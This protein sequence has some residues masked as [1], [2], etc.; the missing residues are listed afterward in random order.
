MLP[1]FLNRFTSSDIDNMIKIGKIYFN[2]SSL[3][4]AYLLDSMPDI[5]SSLVS[6]P[7]DS[8][9]FSTAQVKNTVDYNISYYTTSSIQTSSLDQLS[10]QVI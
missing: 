5:T 10:Q 9:I 7:I 1:S 2:S 3:G 8:T 4:A 6:I